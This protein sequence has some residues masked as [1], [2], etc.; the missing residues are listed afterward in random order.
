MLSKKIE[1]LSKIFFNYRLYK[2]TNILNK[3]IGLFN[4]NKKN[5]FYE[6]KF[7]R[8]K[9]NKYKDNFLSKIYPPKLFLIKNINFNK[10]IFQKIE[11]YKKNNPVNEYDLHGH[12]NTYQSLHDL[13]EGGK[14]FDE[15]SEL[16]LEIIKKK[17]SPIIMIRSQMLN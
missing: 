1:Y 13:N 14:D 9:N 17:L 3:L 12:M 10:N 8:R 7:Y 15:I 11:D 4:K 5:L 16:I 2:I 6:Y